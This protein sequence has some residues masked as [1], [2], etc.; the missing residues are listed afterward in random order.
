MVAFF[1]LRKLI[2]SMERSFNEQ[3]VIQEKWPTPNGIAATFY[4]EQPAKPIVAKE[5][6]A[7]I[8]RLHGHE[9]TTVGNY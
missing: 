8:S 4:V 6:S 5:T 2:A 3:Q 7:L 1:E 9:T